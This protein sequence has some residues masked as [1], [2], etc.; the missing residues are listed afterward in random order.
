MKVNC[1]RHLVAEL[2]IL[3]PEMMR[4]EFERV[5]V[6]LVPI[7]ECADLYGPVLYRS[8][9]LGAHILFLYHLS[10]GWLDR[11]WPQVKEWIRYLR[12]RAFIPE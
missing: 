1:A 10:R 12:E 7:E 6:G 9:E 3:R 2:R 8:A 5:G 11:Q 4:P